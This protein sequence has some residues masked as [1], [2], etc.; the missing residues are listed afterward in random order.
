MFRLREADL[1][2][3][4]PLHAGAMSIPPGPGS[5]AR[6]HPQPRY[7]CEGMIML[8]GIPTRVEGRTLEFQSASWKR[9]LFRRSGWRSALAAG[10]L[11]ASLLVGSAA[12]ADEFDLL[13]VYEEARALNDQWQACAATFIKGRFRTRQTEEWLAELALDRCR[14]EQNDLGEFLIK[15][16]E[17]RERRQRDGAAAREVPIRIDCCH[18]GARAR[19]Q[20]ASPR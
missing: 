12:K 5:G 15:R 18:Y 11:A 14:V 8:G 13:V 1:A 6:A 9:Q 4:C 7:R 16:V 2:A 19:D 3:L 20:M 10:C 17:G